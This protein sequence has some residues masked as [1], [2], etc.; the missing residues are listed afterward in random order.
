MG[1]GVKSLPLRGTPFSKGRIRA[2]VLPVVVVGGDAYVLQLLQYPLLVRFIIVLDI[3]LGF[4]GADV[5]EAQQWTHGK[6]WR[7]ADQ[8]VEAFEQGVV[9]DTQQAADSATS[10]VKKDY[11]N[12]AERWNANSGQ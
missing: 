11:Q 1:K 3:V 10:R 4:P 8:A 6:V 7:F 9:S 12:A 5:D 2:A